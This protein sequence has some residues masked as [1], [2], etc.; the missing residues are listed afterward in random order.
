MF[1]LIL[2]IKLM[3]TS[4]SLYAYTYLAHTTFFSALT[5]PSHNKDDVIYVT[6]SSL[7]FLCHFPLHKTGTDGG[8]TTGV[9]GSTPSEPKSKPSGCTP[10]YTSAV[11]AIILSVSVTLSGRY[12]GW[13]VSLP[14]LIQ[15][16]TSPSAR[17]IHALALVP[18]RNI[19]LLADSFFKRNW[20][21]LSHTQKQCFKRKHDLVV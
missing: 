5:T 16:H 3:D 14:D 6:N 18:D 20:S 11:L 8:D 1:L 9:T 15:C 19:D 7:L 2:V 4:F 17:V 21:T 13:V 10:V 12:F